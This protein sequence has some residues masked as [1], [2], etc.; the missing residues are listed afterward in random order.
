MKDRELL[1]LDIKI[2]YIQHNLNFKKN[3]IFE[4]ISSKN[5]KK[6]H[7]NRFDNIQSFIFVKKYCI[8]KQIVLYTEEYNNKFPIIDI[9]NF[10][11][12]HLAF[13]ILYYSNSKNI[14]F[15]NFSF[16]NKFAKVHNDILKLS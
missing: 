12:A 3:I 14:F 2:K 9:T 7:L 15:S 8:P 6:N 16:D 11:F 1:T 13:L 10:Q 4:K 5:K